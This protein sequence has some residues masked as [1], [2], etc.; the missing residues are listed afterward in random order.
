MLERYKRQ[1]RGS[2]VSWLE[3]Q[4]ISDLLVHGSD[5]LIHAEKV[6][7]I[8]YPVGIKMGRIFSKMGRI[9]SDIRPLF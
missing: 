1:G 4:M 6:G 2:Q 3:Q 9:L 8:K 7:R 5:I